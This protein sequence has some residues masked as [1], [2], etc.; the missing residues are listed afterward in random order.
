LT[1]HQTE[2]FSS[3][4]STENLVQN[5]SREKE[6]WEEKERFVFKKK[7]VNSAKFLPRLETSPKKLKRLND[8]SGN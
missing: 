4:K 3:E 6:T 8:K 1:Q 2:L 7:E 5:F